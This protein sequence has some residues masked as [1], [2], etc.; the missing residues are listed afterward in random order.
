MLVSVIIPVY[1]VKEY[2]E[3]A[4]NSILDQTFSDFEIILCD[5]STDFECRNLCMQLEKSNDKIK[6]LSLSPKCGPGAARNAGMDIARG[7]YIYFMDSDDYVEN[8]ILSD[9]VAIAEKYDCDIVKFGYTALAADNDGNTVSKT[10]ILPVFEGLYSFDMVKEHFDEYLDN[11]SYSVWSRLYKK[12]AVGD[13]RFKKCTTAED[14]IFNMEILFKG[15]K[16]IYFNRKAYYYYIGRPSSIMGKYNPNRYYNESEL[17][18][19]VEKAVED[20]ENHSKLMDKLNEMYI[21]SFLMTYNDFTLPNCD[22]KLGEA[23]K[24]AKDIYDSEDIQKAIKTVPSS[25]ISQPTAK[26][27]YILSLRR[28]FRTAVLFKRVYIPISH[29]VKKLRMR[30]WNLTGN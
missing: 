17:F 12:E 15:I 3:R 1:N 4:V 19:L 8:N 9:N 13:I 27:C 5:N 24:A 11:I 6:L 21:H 29:F 10:D 20:W 30:K 18:K 14:A 25:K 7:K 16:N 26:I 28:K 2:L 23:A 22:L